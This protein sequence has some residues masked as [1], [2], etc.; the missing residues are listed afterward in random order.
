M[1][2]G[3][4][5][6]AL[7]AAVLIYRQGGGAGSG[8]AGAWT[9]RTSSST[10]PARRPP[11][12]PLR[13]RLRGG[14]GSLAH[15]LPDETSGESGEVEWAK[16]TEREKWEYQ[17]A[18][19]HKKWEKEFV[20]N[21]SFVPCAVENGANEGTDDDIMQ[22]LLQQKKL[23]KEI[24]KTRLAEIRS[25]RGAQASFLDEG[26][27][28]VSLIDEMD[29][30]RELPREDLHDAD[31]SEDSPMPDPQD[32]EAT[33][34]FMFKKLLHM[35]RRNEDETRFDNHEDEA[36]LNETPFFG[37]RPD[38]DRDKAMEIFR[39]EV[40]YANNVI[41]APVVDEDGRIY[42]VSGTEEQLLAQHGIFNFPLVSTADFARV[43][44]QCA[45]SAASALDAWEMF[46]GKDLEGFDT[47]CL[48]HKKWG[49]EVEFFIGSRGKFKTRPSPLHQITTVEVDGSYFEW[50]PGFEEMDAPHIFDYMWERYNSSDPELNAWRAGGRDWVEAM[51]GADGYLFQRGEAVAPSGAEPIDLAALRSEH[52]WVPCQDRWAD[53]DLFNTTYIRP[54]LGADG[55][56]D[57][58]VLQAHGA[59]PLVR[60][61]CAPLQG[62][63]CARE[64]GGRVV[65]TN[66][67]SLCEL[68]LTTEGFVFL[69]DWDRW[70]GARPRAVRWVVG[71]RSCV[72]ELGK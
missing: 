24:R 57:G 16:L 30:A 65:W 6:L 37:K 45:P 23:R 66:S 7:S 3:T 18:Q 53:F 61:A 14:S 9:A 2:R 46:K 68:H 63:W 22:L 47:I 17:E 71:W 11:Q 59:A 32:R 44:S 34:G 10:G 72:L 60:R 36:L 67:Q 12:R 70:R 56:Q 13:L 69:S 21:S 5:A 62:T 26:A 51:G 49:T 4:F 33:L 25:H 29:P 27:R 54:R 39:K 31:S 38:F 58:H 20:K 1:G 48:H 52:G 35:Q 64:Q 43:A 8:C 41:D 55:D 42:N 50:K 19:D 15:L 28:S 40:E